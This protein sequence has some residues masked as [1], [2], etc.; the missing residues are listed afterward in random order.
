MHA[1]KLLIVTAIVCTPQY[2]SLQRLAAKV[3]ASRGYVAQALYRHF[4]ASQPASRITP[5]RTYCTVCI[6][7]NPQ[8]RTLFFTRIEFSVTTFT[9]SSS[10]STCV[11]YCQLDISPRRGRDANI[12]VRCCSSSDFFLV[13]MTRRGF[14]QHEKTNGIKKF[15]PYA[16]AYFSILLTL[17]PGSIC[18]RLL[19][20]PL[21]SRS[22]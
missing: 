5:A 12:T 16:S 9:G 1:H 13:V 14:W 4:V 7:R 2:K 8:T 22:M 3:R 15:T 20:W 18:L 19:C 21:L 11:S 6:P 10:A 17:T